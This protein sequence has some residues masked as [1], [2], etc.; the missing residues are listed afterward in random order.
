MAQYDDQLSVPKDSPRRTVHRVEH[1]Q[2][3]K[4]RN[5]ALSLPTQVLSTLAFLDTGSVQREM[6]Y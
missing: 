4:A 6:A 2:R 5:H 1:L 3:N